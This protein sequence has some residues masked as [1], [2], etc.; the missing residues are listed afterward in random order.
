M[1]GN[2]YR[3]VRLPGDGVGREVILE[4]D[5]VLEAVTD[6]FGIEFE[7]QSF[8]C[9]GQHYLETGE[10]WPDEAFPACRDW[11]DA[12]LLGAVGWPGASLPS[13]DIAGAGIVFGLRFGLDLFANVRPCRL[14]PGIKHKIHGAFREVWEPGKVDMLLIRENTEGSYTPTRGTLSRGG[15]DEVAID[16]RVITRK[17]A[18]RVHRFGFELAKTR[19]GAPADGKSRVTC[20]DKS[21]VRAGCRLFRAVYDEVAAGYPDIERDYAYVDAFTQ[22]LVR[23]PEYY[24]VVVAPNMLGDIVT[25]L[26]SVLQGGMGMAA[27]GNIGDRHAMFEPVHGSAP[28]HAGQG[29]ANPLAMVDSVRLMLEHLAL[30]HDDARAKEAATAVEEAVRQVVAD[31]RTLSYDLGGSATTSQV[32][33]AVVAALKTATIAR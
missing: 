6:R 1:A 16:S 13:G 5:K 33:D 14:H 3:I 9:G 32:G 22:W 23:N 2:A 7:T 30:R 8:P 27:S 25:D 24:D 29:K 21:N 20:V 28:K 15:I 31:G 4:A 18:E 26:A 10:E 17:G 11:S 12:I 19:N